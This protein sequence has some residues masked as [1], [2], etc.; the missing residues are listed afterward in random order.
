[1]QEQCMSCSHFRGSFEKSRPSCT[2]F[3]VGI[4]DAIWIGD[5]DHNSPFEGDKGIRF[6][7]VVEGE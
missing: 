3:P 7:A 5:F 1:M 6:E 4:P 2:A